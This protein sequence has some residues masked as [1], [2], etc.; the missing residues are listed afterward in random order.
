[1]TY[2]SDINARFGVV[3]Y[4]EQVIDADA[5]NQSIATILGTLPGQRLFRPQFGC[6]LYNK[7]FEP[8][9]DDTAGSIEIIIKSS[10]KKWEPRIKLNSVNVYV[11]YKTQIYHIECKY[12]I[13]YTNNSSSFEFSLSKQKG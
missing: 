9:N 13:L 11:D 3:N 12:V 2:Y 6:L 10:I 5:I 1:M 8:M 4:K 7:L